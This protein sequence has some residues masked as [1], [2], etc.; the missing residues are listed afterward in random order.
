MN[1]AIPIS[2][3]FIRMIHR[4]SVIVNYNGKNYEFQREDWTDE[5]WDIFIH[6][7]DCN[8]MNAVQLDT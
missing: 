8:L 6:F 1:V 3:N 5:F 2:S 4:I 7:F